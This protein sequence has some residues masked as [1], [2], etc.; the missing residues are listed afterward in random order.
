MMLP[1]LAHVIAK[2]TPLHMLAQTL[3]PLDRQNI[4][5]SCNTVQCHI[6]IYIM[7]VER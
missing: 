4:L 2:A 5:L 6:Y 3:S 1:S 7:E